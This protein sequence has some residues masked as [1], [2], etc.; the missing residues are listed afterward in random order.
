MAVS[1]QDPISRDDV[2]RSYDVVAADYAGPFIG[3]LEHKPLDRALLAAFADRFRALDSADAV[4]QVLEIG[5]GPGHITSYLTTL[6]VR[7]RGIDLSPAMIAEA[8][9]RYPDLDFSVGPVRFAI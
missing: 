7:A 5:C 9:R 1:P 8:R 4:G 3:E 2:R 6:R